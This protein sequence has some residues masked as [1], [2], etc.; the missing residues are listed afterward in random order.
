MSDDRIYKAFKKEAA[1]RVMMC[2]E[3]HRMGDGESPESNR[4]CLLRARMVVMVR[5]QLLKLD[6]LKLFSKLMLLACLV[7]LP[8]VAESWWC[9]ASPKEKKKLFKKKKPKGKQ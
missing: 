4:I 7:N 1:H 9:W 8:R 3:N 5:E 2:D 6:P